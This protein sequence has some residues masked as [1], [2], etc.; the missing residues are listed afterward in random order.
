MVRVRFA[1][2][3]TGELHLGG[4]RTALYNYLFAKKMG[5]KFII[6]LE[7]TDKERFVEGSLDRILNG[8]SWLGITWDEGPDVNGPY[9]P[10]IQSERLTIYQNHAQELIKKGAAYYCFCSQQ[11]L[12][13]LRQVQQ[14]ENQITKYDRNC[15]K[16]SEVELKEKLEAKIPFVVRLKTPSGITFF[17]DIIRGDIKVDNASLD[18]SVL[19]KSDGYPTYHLANVVDDH[20]M[21]ITHVIRG[22]EWLPS[23]P[24]HLLIYAGF[25]WSPPLFAH[26]PNVLNDKKAKLSKR[27]DGES[28]WLYTY[29]AKGYLPSALVNFLSLLGWHPKDDQ[30]VFNLADLEQVF[31][32]ERVQKAGAIFNLAKLD[33][34]NA[35][36]IRK[37]PPTE[38]NN[39]LEPYYK[40]LKSAS[41]KNNIDTLQLTELLQERLI[42]LHSINEHSQWFFTDHLEINAE[43]LIP[44]K[45]SKDKALHAIRSAHN[46]L[47]SLADWSKEEIKNALDVLVRP[48][49]FS[50]GELLWPI[51][52]ALTGQRESP[53]VFGVAFVLGQKES[54]NRLNQAIDLLNK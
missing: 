40:D 49:T 34:F 50:R 18:D 7:D 20:I 37:L 10:Y 31:E 26:L 51:R 21:E 30:E 48:G 44:K 1:P 22:E 15:L 38:L 41:N 14:A 52:V 17:K 53:D 19:L 33:W 3:P 2:S 27:R 24:K 13:V 8:L 23:A 9:A 46:V 35:N 12:E 16:L 42:T 43:L 54:L 6:R 36:Y 47:H 29:R 4:A 32:L 28:V 45:G 25:G 39:L 5:G 11:R